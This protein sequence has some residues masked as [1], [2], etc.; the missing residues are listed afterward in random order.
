MGKNALTFKPG[1]SGN[2]A[3]RPVGSSNK[4]LVEI[5]QNIFTPED[6]IDCLRAILT[7]NRRHLKQYNLKLSDVTAAKWRKALEQ[8]SQVKL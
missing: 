6:K 8:I 4:D 3:G 1:E 5:A 7:K 2:N